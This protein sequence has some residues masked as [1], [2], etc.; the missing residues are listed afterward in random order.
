MIKILPRQCKQFHSNDQPGVEASSPSPCE[1][2]S[3]LTT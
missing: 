2:S 1:N 3:Q